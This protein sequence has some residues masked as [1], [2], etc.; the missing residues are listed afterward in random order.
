MLAPMRAAAQLAVADVTT[1]GG[2]LDEPVQ[3][4]DGDDGTD[5]AVAKRT[6]A[7]H[8][9]AGVDVII[10]AGASGVTRAVLPAV[11]GAGRILFSPCN[12]AADL[13]TADDKGLYF[14]TAP[15]DIL[16]GKALADVILRDGVQK[17][18]IVARDDAYGA[19]LQ[20]IVKA[21]L[22]RAGLPAEQIRTIAYSSA[23]D[24]GTDFT[25]TANEVR[26]FGPDG[27]L[28]IGFSE[29]AEVIKALAA[30]GLTLRH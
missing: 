26:Q 7:A 21:E 4:I 16:Q 24:A 5:P 13:T 1:A 30:A 17:V 27:A 23:P 25:A 3:W 6:V 22:E 8:V 15:S 18:A 29:S 2:V 28:V 10:G 20:E 12:T 19:G 11:I 14:R 9:K